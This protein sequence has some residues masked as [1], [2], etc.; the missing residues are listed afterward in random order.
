MFQMFILTLSLSTARTKLS[1]N[2]LAWKLQ[3]IISQKRVLT[4]S[5]FLHKHLRSIQS[6][7]F[8]LWTTII[9]VWESSGDWLEFSMN[10]V[11][12]FYYNHKGRGGLKLVHNYTP[13][14][15]WIEFKMSDTGGRWIRQLRISNYP[16]T[17]TN[18]VKFNQTAF[19]GDN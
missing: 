17:L 16:S 13:L 9:Y 4:F 8:W 11:F 18:T 14:S 6:S 7:S 1:S 15:I 19:M 2:F 3:T 5:D 10:I 12:F